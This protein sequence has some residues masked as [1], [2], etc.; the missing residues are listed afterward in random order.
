MSGFDD[1][2]KEL[3]ETVKRTVFDVSYGKWFSKP[4]TMS[5]EEMEA[6]GFAIGTLTVDP[7]DVE[8]DGLPLRTCIAIDKRLRRFDGIGAVDGMRMSLTQAQRAAV[9]DHWSAELRAKVAA[10]AAADKE[11]DNRRVLVDMEDM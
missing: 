3:D 2:W 4:R 5:R 9:S 6:A 10:S 1:A 7:L 11:R 8:Y